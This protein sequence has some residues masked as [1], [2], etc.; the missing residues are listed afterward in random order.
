MI[1]RGNIR[2]IIAGGNDRQC[3]KPDHS[4]ITCLSLMSFLN[5]SKASHCHRQDTG[6][7][8][9]LPKAVQLPVKADLP[10]LH[11]LSPVFL[12]SPVPQRLSHGGKWVTSVF[13]AGAN[14]RDMGIRKTIP[15]S[16]S[17][18]SHKTY[19]KLCIYTSV[20]VVSAFKYRWN[21]GHN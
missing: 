1:H 10:F 18:A 9:R 21:L 6:F 7:K 17:T 3:L 4:V 20:P 14:P 12:L 5:L 19:F 16:S 13:A 11:A 2:L 8:V 15:F